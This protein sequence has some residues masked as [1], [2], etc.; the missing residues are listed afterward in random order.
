MVSIRRIGS[1]DCFFCIRCS[2][3]RSGGTDLLSIPPYNLENSVYRN[4]SKCKKTMIQ[5]YQGV[6]IFFSSLHSCFCLVQKSFGLNIGVFAYYTILL[7][8]IKKFLINIAHIAGVSF[9]QSKLSQQLR[10]NLFIFILEV[11]KKMAALQHFPSMLS[12]Q[13]GLYHYVTS[14]KSDYK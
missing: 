13:Q 5:C 14:K 8:N 11:N 7:V 6:Y 9:C 10:A 3:R 12:Q 2:I 1:T 4:I